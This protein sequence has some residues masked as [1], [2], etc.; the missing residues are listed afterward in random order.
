LVLVGASDALMAI[1]LVSCDIYYLSPKSDSEQRLT[2]GT[3]DAKGEE[4]RLGAAFKGVI[5]KRGDRLSGR[6]KA[7]AQF[8]PQRE[9]LEKYFSNA[10]VC[11]SDRVTYSWLTKPLWALFGLEI[12]LSP[13][14][15]YSVLSDS[16]ILSALAGLFLRPMLQSL[17][18]ISLS[19]NWIFL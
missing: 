13:A 3:E 5:A 2:R 14:I 18:S 6:E 12:C 9:T 15:V 4:S 19:I 8:H 10:S 11:G 17:F 16:F 7:I 1:G